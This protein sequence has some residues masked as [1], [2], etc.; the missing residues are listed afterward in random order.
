MRDTHT[1]CI[2]VMKCFVLLQG[3]LPGVVVANLISMVA[4]Y[5]SAITS[6]QNSNYFCS[7]IIVL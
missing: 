7:E 5:H 2:V 4:M 3:R 1:R 6:A